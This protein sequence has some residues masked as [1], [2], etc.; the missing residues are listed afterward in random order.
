VVVVEVH[1]HEEVEEVGLD[2]QEEG[3]EAGHD[4]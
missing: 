2:H 4:H 1:H 3:V